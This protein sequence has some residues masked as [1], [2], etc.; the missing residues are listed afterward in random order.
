[1]RGV[2][3][4]SK[5][6]NRREEVDLP[7]VGRVALLSLPDLVKATKTQRDKDWPMIRR[8]IEADMARSPENPDAA[9]ILF[10]LRECRTSR[11]LSDLAG[12]FPKPAMRIARK[13]PALRAA[14]RGNQS[15]TS[16]L[17]REEEDRE[18]ERDRRYWAPL[19]A[20]LER[21]RR[22]RPRDA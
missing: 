8:L 2:D 1:M 4:F 12:R 15:R 17:L 19:R 14:M 5:L 16:V 11:L 10:W 9:R 22:S 18:R 20:E 13:R 3:S 6:W 21:W 7:G